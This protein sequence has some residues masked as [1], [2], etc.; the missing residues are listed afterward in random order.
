MF[1]HRIIIIPLLCGAMCSM[2]LCGKGLIKMFLYHI[3][4]I[5]HIVAHRLLH[6]AMCDYVFYMIYVVK[7]SFSLFFT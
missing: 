3:V 1:K 4:H 7:S 2:I 5:V 6:P